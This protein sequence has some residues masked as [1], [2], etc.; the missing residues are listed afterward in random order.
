MTD[1]LLP[2]SHGRSRLSLATSYLDE[3]MIMLY[4]KTYDSNR[5]ERNG[6]SHQRTP[7]SCLYRDC[8]LEYLGKL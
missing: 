6:K 3:S 8:L 4:S 2:L 1:R 7:R 5:K